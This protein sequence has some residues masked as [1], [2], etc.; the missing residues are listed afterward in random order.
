MF[1]CNAADM[2]WIYV[3]YLIWLLWICLSLAFTGRFHTAYKHQAVVI[4]FSKL[5][6]LIHSSFPL[7]SGSPPSWG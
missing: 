7:Y 6:K 2:Y 5:E 1:M 3:L 4:G